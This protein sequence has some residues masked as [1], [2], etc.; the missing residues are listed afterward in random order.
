KKLGISAAHFDKIT[1][2]LLPKYYHH[3][4]EGDGKKTLYFLSSYVPYMKHYYAEMK[5]QIKYA[6]AHFNFEE[7]KE[8]YEA[9]LNYYQHFVPIAYREEKAFKDIAENY[10]AI[11][12]GNQ[13]VETKLRMDTKTILF[14]IQNE[15][16]K[17]KIKKQEDDFR[18][19]IDALGKLPDFAGPELVFDY[20][21]LKIYLYYAVEKF[22][23][24]LAVCSEAE[25]ALRKFK[26]PANDLNIM[27]VKLRQ[28]EQ[29]YFLSRFDESYKHFNSVFT[30]PN[31][32]QIP[33]R[34]YYV[35]K[36]IQISLITGHIENA[37]KILEETRAKYGP[38]LTDMVNPRDTFSLIKY[39]MFSEEYDEAF[40]LIQV[41]MEK[42]PKNQYFQYE[43]EL[44]NLQTA[45]FFL[46][47]QYEF[48]L[49]VC[50][51]HIKFLRMHGY[52]LK[53]SDYAYFYI[54]TKAIFREG[55]GGAKLNQRELDKLERFQRGSYAIYGRLLLK[56][57][58][59]MQKHRE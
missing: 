12:T 9:C 10:V 57:R 20:Y 23:V 29:L 14:A 4:F 17:A 8:F 54:L 41:G 51:K 22:E 37:A 16:A 34:G 47:G 19:K 36:Y 56:M 38:V 3:L 49:D 24:S 28:S 59:R 27:R 58:S 39:F 1:S 33:D 6:N 46:T 13:R 26:T 44:R 25:I 7:K 21:W 43:I 35:T 18:K 53:T 31:N 30:S 50:N 32:Q 5:R 40:K 2:E 15:F 55:S 52:G 42:N 11:F 48:A 45:Y